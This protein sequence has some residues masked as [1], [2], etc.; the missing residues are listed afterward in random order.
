MARGAGRGRGRQ[1]PRP[2]ACR[3]VAATLPAATPPTRQSSSTTWTR[4]RSTPV[5][6]ARAVGGLT[7]WSTATRR[8][9]LT[10]VSG[11]VHAAVGPA[12]G[13][14]LLARRMHET[15]WR[16][17]RGERDHAGIDVRA[18]WPYPDAATSARR[19]CGLSAQGRRP[20]PGTWRS[21]GRATVSRQLPQPGP[22]LAKAPA[23]MVRRLTEHSPD[24]AYGTAARLKAPSSSWPATPAVT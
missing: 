23:E 4:P 1:Q 13:Y 22:F 15:R 11:A 5:R 3:A 10:E 7:F 19:P 16:A 6:A 21:T 9:R 24:E 14:F 18:G 12:T 8:G 2:E 20:R 17:R